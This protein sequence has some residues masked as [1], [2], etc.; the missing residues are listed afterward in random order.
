MTSRVTLSTRGLA[1]LPSVKYPDEFDF[2]IGDTHFRCSAVSADFLSP[3]I[4]RFHAADPFCDH[5]YMLT[6]TAS[7]EFNNVLALSRGASIEITDANRSVLLSIGAELENLELCSLIVNE[8]DENLQL[9]ALFEK[10][11]LF[12]RFQL[13]VSALVPI[14]SSH[15]SE[16]S[17]EFLQSLTYDDFVLFLSSDALKL[18]DEDSLY[19]LL[20]SHFSQ[21]PHFFGLLEFV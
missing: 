4:A 7:D 11:Q 5:Y 20:S 14:L 19:E 15:F 3:K 9:S 13:D 21:D 2:I 12:R 1:N 10:F 17:D 18:K 16:F 6:L 8:H